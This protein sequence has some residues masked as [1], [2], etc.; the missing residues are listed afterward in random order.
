MTGFNE[1]PCN[2]IKIIDRDKDGKT[3]P[4]KKYRVKSL[5][6]NGQVVEKHLIP[7]PEF[8]DTKIIVRIFKEDGTEDVAQQQIVDKPVEVFP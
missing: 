6:I 3:I 8:N 4:E 5:G 2:T 1:I 7:I